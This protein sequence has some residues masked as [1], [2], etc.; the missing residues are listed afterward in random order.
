[1]TS[2]ADSFARL[3]SIESQYNLALRLGLRDLSTK[4]LDWDQ[5]TIPQPSHE[6]LVL[7]EAACLLSA[8]NELPQPL[9]DAFSPFLKDKAAFNRV[10]HNF[11]VLS[12]DTKFRQE[13]ILD[14]LGALESVREK[15]GS[16]EATGHEDALMAGLQDLPEPLRAALLPITNDEAMAGQIRASLVNLQLNRAHREESARDFL[17]A[18]SGHDDD[19][20][21]D[22]LHEDDLHEDGHDHPS[23]GEQRAGD[24]GG[25]PFRG[26]GT[27]SGSGGEGSASGGNSQSSP[28]GGD[29]VVQEGPAVTTKGP[30]HLQPPEE[31]FLDWSTLEGHELQPKPD[32]LGARHMAI[33]ALW[34]DIKVKVSASGFGI[35]LEGIFKLLR[36][37]LHRDD[38]MAYYRSVDRSILLPRLNDRDDGQ[39]GHHDTSQRSIDELGKLDVMLFDTSK[40]NGFDTHLTS[41]TYGD[42][43]YGTIMLFELK[44]PDRRPKTLRPVAAMKEVPRIVLEK[45]SNGVPPGSS[46]TTLSMPHHEI[47]KGTEQKEVRWG[48][49]K[50]LTPRLVPYK[51]SGGNDGRIENAL[52][53]SLSLDDDDQ[54]WSRVRATIP[55]MIAMLHHKAQLIENIESTPVYDETSG[56]YHGVQMVRA[57]RRTSHSS[58][59]GVRVI[60]LAPAR[61]NWIAQELSWK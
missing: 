54:T 22:D 6:A 16:T 19:L 15:D 30:S 24:S 56:D 46:R 51:D 55:Q 4:E 20:H 38:F 57:P 47:W 52:K 44:R 48:I 58:S 28:E 29:G 40:F 61:G 5:A 27:G 34:N 23:R 53:I 3:S 59:T 9:Q 8:V 37:C 50:G 18:L 25:L 41:V 31:K 1:M 21:E 12:R 33:L 42:D 36:E 39:E 13:I 14:F 49:K 2:T 32:I 60:V 10:L 7:V 43:K 45:I 26:S 17:D 11:S 35:E